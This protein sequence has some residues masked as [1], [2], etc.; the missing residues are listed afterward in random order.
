MGQAFG[1]V[2]ALALFWLHSGFEADWLVKTIDF[3]YLTTLAGWLLA[4]ILFVW[5]LPS[6]LAE[7]P[8]LALWLGMVPAAL[9]LATASLGMGQSGLATRGADSCDV[10][11]MAGFLSQR[12]TWLGLLAGGSMWLGALWPLIAG[13]RERVH[14]GGKE[15][16]WVYSAAVVSLAGTFICTFLDPLL[17]SRAEVGGAAVR[18]M[19]LPVAWIGALWLWARRIWWL[20]PA[21]FR[22]AATLAAAIGLLALGLAFVGYHRAQGLFGFMFDPLGVQAQGAS[23]GLVVAIAVLRSSPFVLLVVALSI[24]VVFWPSVT[25]PW[26]RAAYLLAAVLAIAA[27]WLGTSAGLRTGHGENCAGPPVAG[28]DLPVLNTGSTGRAM[29]PDGLVLSLSPEQLWIDGQVLSNED[30]LSEEL[31][32]DQ[33]REQ[34]VNLAVDREV[35]LQRLWGVVETMGRQGIC[36]FKLLAEAATTRGNPCPRDRRLFGFCLENRRLELAF[37]V[38]CIGKSTPGRGSRS[39]PPPGVVA[40]LI[41]EPGRLELSFGGFGIENRALEQMGGEIENVAGGYDLEE[42]IEHLARARR[43]HPESR[44]L[45]LAAH[46]AMMVDDLA[47]L[48]QASKGHLGMELFPEVVL[49][50]LMR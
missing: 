20:R 46:E 6:S 18:E 8:L 11:L 23:D 29:A 45:L 34:V 4:L 1:L 42:L 25:L 43:E 32:I 7:R 30:R 48:L 5:W 33:V 9:G 2:V 38:P 37:S 41:A 21:S 26:R 19:W 39:S 17:P 14:P 47:A 13:A 3:P 35:R 31:E 12:S 44:R 27:L 36:R 22:L 15:T 40:N 50:P 28:I 10:W 24:A 49:T 16:I